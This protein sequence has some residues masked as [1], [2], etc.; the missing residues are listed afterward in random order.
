MSDINTDHTNLEIP[1]WFKVV[2]I[3]AI[4]WNLMGVMAFMATVMITPQMLAELPQA[5]QDLHNATPGWATAAFGVAVWAGVLGSI[6]LLLKKAL[7]IPI[8]ILSLLAIL[9]QMYHAFFISNSFAVF[10]PGGMIMPTMVITIA[11]VLIV[12]A[13]NA[14]SK[15]WLN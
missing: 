13:T 5:E 8:L 15:H 9:V 11:S 4:V 6:A 2:C 7:A 3:L 1:T 10:G 12:L 14:K